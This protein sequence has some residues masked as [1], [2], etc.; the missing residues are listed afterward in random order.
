MCRISFIYSFL[1]LVSV[2]NIIIKGT[3]GNTIK[4]GTDKSYKD[5]NRPTIRMDCELVFVAGYEAP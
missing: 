2:L 4:N 5:K 3:F 1:R